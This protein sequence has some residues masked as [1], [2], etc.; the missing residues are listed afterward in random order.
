MGCVM[1]TLSVSGLDR[2][3]CV[4]DDNMQCFMAG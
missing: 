1:V 2:V 4:T 3:G